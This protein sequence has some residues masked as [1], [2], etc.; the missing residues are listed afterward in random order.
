M[1]ARKTIAKNA[2]AAVFAAASFSSAVA[3]D[4]SAITCVQNLMDRD[5]PKTV[6][7]ISRK[8][9][10]AYRVDMKETSNIFGAVTNRSAT[11]QENITCVQKLG[12]AEVGLLERLPRQVAPVERPP[13]LGGRSRVLGPAVD[14]GALLREAARPQAVDEHPVPVVRG[15]I[16]VDP[17]QPHRHATM[18][19]RPLAWWW[20]PGQK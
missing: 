11:V 9:N 10:G 7:T 3:Q 15:R 14:G 20:H 17:L 8:D 16:V 5:G 13:Q 2:L 6:I 19:P 1:T 18:M 4:M 12:V